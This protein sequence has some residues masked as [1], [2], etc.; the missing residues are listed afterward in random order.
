HGGPGLLGGDAMKATHLQTTAIL[1]ALSMLPAQA[2]RAAEAAPAPATAPAANEVEA[3]VV[4]GRF[5]DTGAKSAMKMNV[6]VLDTPFSVASY[7][8]SFVKSIDTSELASLYSY[9]TGV[10]KAGNT[11]YD[12]NLR[13]F[14]SSGTDPNAILVDGLPGLTGR[15]NSPPT[16]G[17][18]RVELVKGPMSVLYGQMQPGGFVNMITKKPEAHRSTEIE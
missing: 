5:F 1:L 17:I 10:K 12:I 15:Y 2:A 18:Q 16:V 4:T 7:S 9:M 14:S 6:T 3:V 8:D 11:G 13:G